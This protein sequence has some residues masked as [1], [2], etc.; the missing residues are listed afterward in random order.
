MV[1]DIPAGDGKTANFFY[2][3]DERLSYAVAPPSLQLALVEDLHP[4]VAVLLLQSQGTHH[5][6]LLLRTPKIAYVLSKTIE[7]LCV[8]K[9]TYGTDGFRGYNRL[10]SS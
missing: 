9:F 5:F 1:S 7:N 8:L 3:V 2:S 4:P 6:L 10:E